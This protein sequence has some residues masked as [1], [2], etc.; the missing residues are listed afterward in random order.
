MPHEVKDALMR[1]ARAE[2]R[3]AS[4]VVRGFI[5]SYLA[6]QPKE[7]RSMFLTLWK[8]AA[9]IGAAS[10]AIIWA[11]LS[12]TPSQATPDLKSVFNML[13]RNHDGVITIDEFVSDASDPA[14]EKM[15]HSHLRDGARAKQM[16]AVHVQAMQATHA[17]PAD[18]ALRSHFAQLDT[19]TD[20]S[21]TFEEFKAYH[22][23]M[24][25][26]HGH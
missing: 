1:Q 7:A 22:D 23:K 6:G 17:K 10:L 13:D 3:S 19:N 16:G 24:R 15:H 12:P 14:I 18:Q 21:V 20:G 4:E 25:R 11:A 9:A 5:D 8:P 2:G 26:M